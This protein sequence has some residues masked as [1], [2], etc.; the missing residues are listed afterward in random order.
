MGQRQLVMVVGGQD[1]SSSQEGEK[2]SLPIRLVI[3]IMKKPLKRD[4]FSKD[5]SLRKNNKKRK[6]SALPLNTW[7]W[8]LEGRLINLRTKL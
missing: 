2:T 4:L 3:Q 5:M 8:S 6:G 7:V 1:A